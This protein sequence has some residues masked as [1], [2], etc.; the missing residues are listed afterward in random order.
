MYI[1]IVL[2]ALRVTITSADQTS[3]NHHKYEKR[4]MCKIK[5]STVY[6]FERVHLDCVCVGGKG[7]GVGLSI[8]VV[9]VSIK[10]SI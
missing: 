4:Y 6:A 9:Q 5:I 8:K 7:G 3:G 2:I 10:G 1:Q